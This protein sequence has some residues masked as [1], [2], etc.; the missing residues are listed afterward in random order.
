MR[1]VEGR[2]IR[3]RPASERFDEKVDRRDR[4]GCWEWTGCR[5]RKGYGRFNAGRPGL[6]HRFA[7]ERENGPIPPGLLVCHRCDNPSCV[8]PAHLFLGTPADNSADMVR[9]GRSP[10]SPGERSGKCRLTDRQVEI[11]RWRAACGTPLNEIADEFGVHPSYVS[12]LVR[13]ERRGAA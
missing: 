10:R 3:R 13:H 9:K 8:N 6:A 5:S 4:D 7:Y 1:V 12:R 11:I 2:P